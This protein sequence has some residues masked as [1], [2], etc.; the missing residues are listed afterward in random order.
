MLC[1]KNVSRNLRTVT[2]NA[3]FRVHSGVIKP[4]LIQNHFKTAQIPLISDKHH[5][6]FMKPKMR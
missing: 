3:R 6:E 2:I 4:S 5:S 1:H